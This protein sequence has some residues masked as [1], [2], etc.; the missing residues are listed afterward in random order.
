MATKKHK[1]R[2]DASVVAQE[3]KKVEA[4]IQRP[5][6][7][8]EAIVSLKPSQIFT[9]PE[10]FQPRTFSAGLREHDSG[11]VKKLE[12]R[13]KIEGELDALTVVKLDGIW[14]CVD[15]HHRLEAYRRQ[16]WSAEIS[17]RWMAGSVKEA[18][19]EGARENKKIKLEMAQSDKFEQAWIRVVLEWGSKQAII[20]ATGVSDGM[21]ALMRRVKTSCEEKDK[22]GAELRAKIGDL[23]Q[24]SWSFA[25][26]VYVNA[27][28]KDWSAREA[29]AKLA[30]RMSSRLTNLLS[31][32]PQV[33]AHALALYDPDLVGPLC[34]AL[35]RYRYGVPEEAE[36]AEL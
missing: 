26:S 2:R 1:I 20:K 6:E 7:N 35:V 17:C 27:E 23:R 36:E 9:R 8:K 4:T 14:T 11:Y 28:P 30:R 29:A 10:L 32:D 12:R 15:G 13:I 19:D 16:K 18:I 33:T 3:L 31:R 5:P 25:R 22:F 21:V 34:D 24:A